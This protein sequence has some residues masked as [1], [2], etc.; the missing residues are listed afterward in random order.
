MPTSTFV[1]LSREKQTTIFQSAL[2]EFSIKGYSLASTN[3]IAKKSGISKGSIF[4][5]FYT[6]EDLFFFV[7]RRALSEVI[8]VYKDQ[9]IINFDNM[10]LKIFFIVSCLQLIEV[11]KKYPYH[12][13]LYIRIHYDIDSPNYKETRR[14][15]NRYISAITIKLIELGKSRKIIRENIPSDFI[16]FFM[17]NFLFRF[18]EVRFDPDI[19]PTLDVSYFSEEKLIDSLNM[20]YN[21]FIEGIG[22]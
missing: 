19:E 4:Q 14:Y 15:L 12:Y 16:L 13:K 5:Y 6:K 22:Y 1:G 21:L 11:Y 7:V 17:N 9:Y 20:V 18:V 8:K 2:K 10:D 3:V